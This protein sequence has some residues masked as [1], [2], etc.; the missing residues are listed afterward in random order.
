MLLDREWLV[1]DVSTFQDPPTIDYDKWATQID[2][3][4]I[5]IGYTGHT[6]GLNQVI[7]TDFKDHY[8]EFT[9]RGIPVGTYFYGVAMTPEVARQEA[10]ATI[11]WL[12]SVDAK[13]ELPAFYDTESTQP[14]HTPGIGHQYLDKD[15]LT[16]VIDTYCE[17][18]AEHNIYPGIYANMWWFED[19]THMDI[20]DRW[21]WWVAKWSEPPPRIKW[22]MWQYTNAGT[23]DG[24]NGPLDLNKM[25]RDWPSIIREGEWNDLEPLPKKRK[26]MP[27][28]MMINYN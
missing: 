27:I 1:V 16:A 6:T 12:E 19:R 3:A 2:G 20:L 15:T 4:V 22:G 11:E 21:D 8:R 5:R 28:W 7:D 13:L 25:V 14:G 24:F 23:L 26:G 10:L 18:M 17:T 9:S